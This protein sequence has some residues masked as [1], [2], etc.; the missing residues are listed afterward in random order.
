MGFVFFSGV[1]RGD[2]VASFKPFLWLVRDSETCF[3]GVVLVG[4][5][6]TAPDEEL[7]GVEVTG[8]GSGSGEGVCTGFRAEVLA[9]GSAS[10]TGDCTA[11]VLGR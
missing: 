5:C 1:V 6:P 4:C 10:G 11:V 3:C 8:A 9:D 7:R 2:A